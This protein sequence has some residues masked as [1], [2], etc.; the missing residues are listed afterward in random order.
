VLYGVASVRYIYRHVA[1]FVLQFPAYKFTNT[2]FLFSKNTKSTK[3]VVGT[4]ATQL[5]IHKQDTMTLTTYSLII[6]V[7]ITYSYSHSTKA[8]SHFR[9][10]WL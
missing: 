2:V 7:S 4:M 9:V 6:P 10:K 5:S 8:E 3:R 1:T